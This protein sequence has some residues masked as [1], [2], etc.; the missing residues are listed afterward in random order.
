MI[1]RLA[2]LL[3]CA[4]LA[5]QDGPYVQW[6]RGQARI[7]RFDRQGSV[8][9]RTARAPFDLALPGLSAAPLH[10]TGR[11]LPPDGA[12]FP[13]PAEILAV[14][15]IHGNFD[16]FLALLKAHRVVDGRLRWIYGTGHLVIAGDVLDRGNQVTEALWFIRGLEAAAQ[17]QGGRVHLLLGNHEQMVL[18]GDLRYTQP[19]YAQP[20]AGMPSLEARF[21]PESEFGR[22]L[23]AKPA[24]LK[25]GPFL[26]LHGGLSPAL[27]AKGMPLAAINTTLREHLAE[28]ANETRGDAAFLLGPEGPLWF[29]GLIPGQAGEASDA[30]VEA[31]LTRFRVRALVVGH[32]TGAEIQSLHGGRV[33]AID[34]GLK[35]GRGEAWIWERGKVFRGLMDGRRVP[36]D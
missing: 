4:L 3:A 36:L 34:A 1:R 13:A 19:K 14:S 11:P 29:R 35:E 28:S 18:S 2:L 20:P 6:D 16:G 17:R 12:A 23:R 24:V 21:G 33:Y 5:A 30:E 9:V 22:W 7:T 32:T 10:L 27:V 31:A 26:F 8:I 25:L 15:D